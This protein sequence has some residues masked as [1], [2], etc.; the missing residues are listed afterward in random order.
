M[1][2]AWSAPSPSR[3]T[4]P[5]AVGNSTCSACASSPMRCRRASWLR[6]PCGVAADRPVA[7]G[8]ARRRARGTAAVSSRR[9]G[10]GRGTGAA[11][12][13]HRRG[14]GRLVELTRIRGGGTG[15]PRSNSLIAGC[16][17]RCAGATDRIIVR[18]MVGL[19]PV[20]DRK[21]AF[22]GAR[23]L[24]RDGRSCGVVLVGT[25]GV[26]KTT[27][28]R[29]LV[30]SLTVRRAGSWHRVHPEHSSRRL[31]AA[32]G[33]DHLARPGRR[34][35][36]GPGRTRRGR[37]GPG[38]RRRHRRR[39]RRPSARR[40]LRGPRA[41]TG[42][43]PRRPPR[44]H[45]PQRGAGPV[46]DRGTVEGRAAHPVRRGAVHPRGDG[47]GTAPGARCPGRAFSADAIWEASEGNPLFL[48]HL[49]EGAL[50]G[51]TLRRSGGVWQ[52]RGRPGCPRRSRRC[53]NHG[54][55]APRETRSTWWTTW[56]SAS[57]S[58]RGAQR[59]RQP[60]LHRGGRAAGLGT[61]PGCRQR[62]RGAARHPLFG[63]VIRDRAGVLAAQRIKRRLVEVLRESPDP[64]VVT[65]MRIAEL[66]VESGIEPDPELLVRGAEDA[67][68]MASL[69]SG[70]GWPLP[71]FAAAAD[72]TRRS[73]SAA[74]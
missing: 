56:R 19:W 52:L 73:R 4:P 23:E 55:P 68:A 1:T 10:P 28:A 18:S 42:G 46:G 63:E 2:V 38:R 24:L 3:S 29:E 32:P 27:M 60:A 8:G 71:P 7:G 25:A 70:P 58:T 21:A 39:R 14:S 35:A 15:R 43:R 69:D 51:G 33:P 5:T 12:D 44:R 20:L 11:D 41:P 49:V 47:R 13:P 74:R 40:V 50:D 67:I 59:T 61:D 17:V 16:A 37:L 53:S 30:G 36:S 57:R 45:G 6:P 22:E 48:R 9:P 26:G 31:R 54:S 34:P 72:S 62:A 65:S 66:A 64:G